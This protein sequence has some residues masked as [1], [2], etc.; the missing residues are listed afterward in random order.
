[1]ARLI[2]FILSSS[3]SR[4]QMELLM[5]QQPPWTAMQPAYYTFAKVEPASYI[6]VEKNSP[7]YPGN[8][9]NFNSTQEGD[10]DEKFEMLATG[11]PLH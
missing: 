8:V 5:Q 2:L 9:G 1:M 7:S 10:N 6:L 3:N 4:N 11:L